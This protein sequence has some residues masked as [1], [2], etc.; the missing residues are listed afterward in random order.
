[1]FKQEIHDDHGSTVF[2]LNVS[3]HAKKAY[4]EEYNATCTRVGETMAFS[5]LLLCAAATLSKCKEKLHKGCTY[6][7]ITFTVNS[8]NQVGCKKKATGVR[9]VVRVRVTG[10]DSATIINDTKTP[11]SRYLFGEVRIPNGKT[12]NDFVMT[13]GVEA[14]KAAI[15]S[16]SKEPLFAGPDVVVQQL[17]KHLDEL[18]NKMGEFCIG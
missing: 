18:I 7:V 11:H 17:N 13:D 14:R 12:Y 1:M 2:T 5:R 8:G 16:V 15:L 9:M 6:R 3:E 4:E 10:A